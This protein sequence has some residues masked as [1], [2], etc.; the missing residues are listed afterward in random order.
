VGI[1]FTGSVQSGGLKVETANGVSKELVWSA[2]GS[3]LTLGC[4]MDNKKSLCQVTK[5]A[6]CHAV[7]NQLLKAGS[8]DVG[9]LSKPRREKRDRGWQPSFED[10]IPRLENLG[11]IWGMMEW[12]SEDKVEIFG[13]LLRVNNSQRTITSSE[14]EQE[15]VMILST[16]GGKWSISSGIYLMVLPSRRLE[17]FSAAFALFFIGRQ[18]SEYTLLQ[19]GCFVSADSQPSLT[20]EDMGKTFG[21][22]M[23]IFFFETPLEYKKSCP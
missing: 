5:A 19:G 23:N 18:R 9:M 13:A 14:V 11:D 10:G 15:E 4:K 7:F 6:G 8:L 2:A 22:W 21:N 20:V 1:S 3:A 16:F 12:Y 17:K